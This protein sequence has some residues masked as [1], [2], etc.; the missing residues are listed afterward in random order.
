MNEAPCA[1]GRST[2]RSSERCIVHGPSDE[3]VASTLPVGSVV[4]ML[5]CE[6]EVEGVVDQRV[7]VHPAPVERRAAAR[8]GRRRSTG[9]ARRGRRSWSFAFATTLN[10]PS[11]VPGSGV[12]EQAASGRAATQ[13]ERD[14][15]VLDEG[16]RSDA[17]P[18]THMRAPPEFD[19]KIR[20]R[21]GLRDH[22]FHVLDLVHGRAAVA[23]AT[24]AIIV[25]VD[26]AFFRVQPRG[27]LVRARGSCPARARR[28]TG[29][30]RTSALHPPR[31]PAAQ[32]AG[33]AVRR[34]A[35][36]RGRR[37]RA[38][39]QLD[40][41]LRR[42]RARAHVVAGGDASAGCRAGATGVGLVTDQFLHGGFLHLVFGMWFLL[43]RLQPRGPLGP[44]RLRA[45]LRER[46]HRGGPGA[47]GG[48]PAE[49]AADHWRVGR[50]CRG[51]GRDPRLVRA[52]AH[53]LRHPYPLP[54]GNV[55][56]AVPAYVMLPMW[57][58][59]EV[60]FGLL[61]GGDGVAH[62][63][64]VGFVMIFALALRATGFERR[65]DEAVE[66]TVSVPQDPRIMRAADTATA[67]CRQRCPAS[68]RWPA[69]APATS[70]CSS[71]APA[72]GEW[73]AHCAQEG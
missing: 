22:D 55:P 7:P 45:V 16:V 41:P 19:V 67:G 33:A 10:V 71:A 32:R 49:P 5:A 2:S 51:D 36:R 31:L 48:A 38:G 6:L 60:A 21:T 73:A 12:A 70:T 15:Q 20:R 53:P 52:H 54:P 4:V 18:V 9:R 40:A 25:A 69:S 26:R 66:R 8:A 72:R 17:L 58:A 62:W 28:T 1:A 11:C 3:S 34:A 39:A 57:I 65:L 61:P 29:Y 35:P 68:A 13:T 64:H 14:T 46:R 47:H 43:V 50:D 63:A 24:I 37:R 59:N 42:R 56:F 30:T 44:P 27:P 23:V